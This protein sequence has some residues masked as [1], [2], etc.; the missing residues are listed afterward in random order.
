MKRN[1]SFYGIAPMALGRGRILLDP[2]ATDPKGDLGEIAKSVKEIGDGVKKSKDELDSRIKTIETELSTVKT[3]N[4]E[5]RRK[6]V[7]R[8]SIGLVEVR[9]PGKVTTECAKYLACVVL[10]SGAAHG[11]NVNENVVKWARKH[12]ENVVLS[13][14]E[15][16]ATHGTLAKYISAVKSNPDTIVRTAL[17][18]ADIPLPVGYAAEVVELVEE[19]GTFRKYAT[20][21]PMS[22]ATV[23]LPKLT[24]DPAFG[25]FDMSEAI[26]EKSPAVANVEFNAKKAGGIVRIPSELNEDS[27]VQLGQFIARYIARQMASFEDTVGWNADGTATYKLLSG[28]VKRIVA[29]GKTAQLGNGLTAPADATLAGLRAIRSKVHN[30]ALAMGAYYFHQSMESVL[31]SF[32]KLENGQVYSAAGANGASLDGFPIRWINKLPPNTTDATVSTVIAAFGDLSFWYMGT[33][34]M[35]RIDTDLSAGFATDELLIRALERFTV[36]EMATD[37]MSGLLT[38]DA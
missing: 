15:S 31:V 19:Y 2:A 35:M 22:E 27:I 6:L 8:S 30:A 23:N 26:G 10:L 17:T 5:L 14:G 38:A 20:V 29:N 32:N 25:F 33:R 1:H 28:V 9:Q 21:F 36:G 37:H 34:G 4:T 3:E 11:K 13:I 12:V 16:D 7:A 18:T 24:T